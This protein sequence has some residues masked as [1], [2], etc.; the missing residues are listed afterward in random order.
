MTMMTREGRRLDL[1]AIQCAV[2]NEPLNTLVEFSENVDE[3]DGYITEIGKLLTIED[4]IQYLK[5]VFKVSVASSSGDARFDKQAL[6][7]GDYIAMLD[8]VI[9]RRWRR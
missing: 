4:K 8:V 2:S 3:A 9:N 5:E 1:D 7:P 6:L